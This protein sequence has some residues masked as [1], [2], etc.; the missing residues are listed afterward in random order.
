MARL[1]RSQMHMSVCWH[2]V[3]HTHVHPPPVRVLEVGALAPNSQV[4]CKAQEALLRLQRLRAALDVALDLGPHLLHAHGV[5][6]RLRDIPVV[7]WPTHTHLLHAH[8]A[9]VGGFAGAGLGGL[10]AAAAAAAAVG[11]VVV[12]REQ[13]VKRLGE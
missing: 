5:G 11:G 10:P 4:L 8:R 6:G 7:E 1:C 3:Y 2:A 12:R 9:A 13:R